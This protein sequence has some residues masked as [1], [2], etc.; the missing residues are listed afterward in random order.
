MVPWQ[1]PKNLPATRLAG[2]SGNSCPE[3]VI[4]ED[5]GEPLVF[6]LP[7]TIAV[8][9]IPLL[10]TGTLGGGPFSSPIKEIAE[11]DGGVGIELFLY[12]RKDPVNVLVRVFDSEGRKWPWT[13]R[14]GVRVDQL[15]IRDQG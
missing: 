5:A 7:K 11:E 6:L 2:P 14:V 13:P 3:P 15:G 10:W 1:V 9:L 8:F 12:E 4:K